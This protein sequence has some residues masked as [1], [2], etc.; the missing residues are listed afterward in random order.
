MAWEDD[1]PVCDDNYNYDT[2]YAGT[3]EDAHLEAQYEDRHVI[4]EDELPPWMDGYDM[5]EE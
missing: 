1:N 3:G 2:F 4:P 5:E